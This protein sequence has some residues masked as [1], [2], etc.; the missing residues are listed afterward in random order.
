MDDK[1]GGGD[2]RR[3]FSKNELVEYLYPLL[4]LVYLAMS[5]LHGAPMII[6]WIL[7]QTY[8]ILKTANEKSTQ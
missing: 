4:V 8:E 1:K 5:I 6:L 2:N 3:P 7:E